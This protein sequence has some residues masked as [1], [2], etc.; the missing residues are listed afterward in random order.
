M[1]AEGAERELQELKGSHELAERELQEL[2][3]VCE[4][5]NIKLRASAL[6][7]DNLEEQLE[8]LKGQY[9]EFQGQYEE[10]KGQY[11]ELRGQYET[12]ELRRA[13]AEARADEAWEVSEQV[14]AALQVWFRR[15]RCEADGVRRGRDGQRGRGI[16]HTMEVPPGV[17]CVDGVL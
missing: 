8:E 16:Q 15:T 11:E 5:A 4:E 9:E 7:A 3:G 12:S 13:E 10:L 6:R 2:K 14:E 1:R 17:D